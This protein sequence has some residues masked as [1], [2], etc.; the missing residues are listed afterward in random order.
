MPKSMYTIISEREALRWFGTVLGRT[1]CANF[2]VKTYCLWHKQLENE[3]NIRGSPCSIFQKMG[4][5]IAIFDLLK[6]GVNGKT[7]TCLPLGSN[8][9]NF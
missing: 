2:F 4:P 8:F 5:N 9:D 6:Y 7:V 3:N 1:K